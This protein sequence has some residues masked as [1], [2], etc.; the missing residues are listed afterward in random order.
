MYFAY[1]SNMLPGQ[2]A[3]RCPGAQPVGK[4]RLPHWKFVCCNR[5]A[6]NVHPRNDHAVH[7]VLWRCNLNHIATLD[8]YEGVRL[9]VYQRRHTII[10]GADNRDYRAIIYINRRHHTGT[11]RPEYLLNAVLPGARAFELPDHYIEEL[12]GWLP[13]RPIGAAGRTYYGRKA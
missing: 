10:T 1:G 2:M 7:G 3:R 12:H 8:R 13:D 11:G 9:G 6:A 4:G 5:G